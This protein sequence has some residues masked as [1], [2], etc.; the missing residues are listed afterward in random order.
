[1]PCHVRLNA[2]VVAQATIGNESLCSQHFMMYLIWRGFCC[3]I[4]SA[5]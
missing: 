5:K 4:L 3:Y 2:E 1:M